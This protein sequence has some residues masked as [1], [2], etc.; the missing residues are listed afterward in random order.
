MLIND[1]P[2]D[3]ELLSAL[4]QRNE[5]VTE[6]RT[7]AVSALAAIPE[8][9]PSLILLGDQLSDMDPLDL[10]AQLRQHPSTNDIPVM[11]ITAGENTG[12]R[13]KGVEMGDA[14]ISY[15]Y[16]NREVLAQVA[17]QV[18]VSK[19]RLAMR[20][21]EKKSRSVMEPAI[22]AIISADHCGHIVSWN[23]AA[24]KILGYTPE[25][26]V[27]KRLELI[28]PERF[29]DVHRNGMQRVTAGGESRAIGITVELSA[30]TKAGT[31]IPIELS[32]ATWKVKEERYY[33]GIIRDIRE[34][35]KA[36][37]TLRK[38]EEKYRRIVETADEGFMLLDENLKIVEANTAICRLLK[39]RLDE[40]I[41]KYLIDFASA[42]YRQNLI[43][44]RT[45]LTHKVLTRMECEFVDSDGRLIPIVL[46]GGVLRDDIGEA[47]GYMAFITDMTEQKKAL[48][49]AVEVQ[50]N[51]LPL[52][53]PAIAGIDIAGRNRS[54]EEIGGDYFDF[55]RRWGMP[56]QSISTVVGDIAGHGLDAALVMASARA[57]LRMRASQPGTLSDIVGDMN[58]HL[59]KDLESTCH[60]MTLF[61]LTIDLKQKSLEWIRAGHDAALLYD[62]SQD[63]F[64]TLRGEG[65][66][67]GIDA[68]SA[69]PISSRKDIGPG[70]VIV[71]GTDGIWEARN[72]H[73]SM[74]GKGRLKHLIRCHHHESAERILA[75]IF[76]A[77]RDYMEDAQ[78]EDDMTMVI[79]KIA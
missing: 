39:H 23:S 79:L 17:R 30:R 51:L 14:L 42:A 78:P 59:S 16:D 61:F 36:E 11:L 8:L 7:T 47:I 56:A 13:I 15:P 40:I 77:L 50:K 64:E 32:L 28:I 37:A 1:N 38:S 72:G 3:D 76:D 49:L 73:G 54:C 22:D 53:P 70:Q 24:T 34:R 68:A 9:K 67:L 35:K 41:G 57:F 60:F 27:G 75:T 74:F 71:V 66:A 5:Y 45:D 43:N 10:L 18:T 69:Y 19:A 62:P 31:E 29:H 12:T 26:A 44:Y 20:E 63:K 52:R 55:I 48:A 46:H 33:T 6:K 4:L 25:E 65:L 2:H 58:K 21:S